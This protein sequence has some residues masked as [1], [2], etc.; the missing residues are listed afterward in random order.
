MRDVGG[1]E[2][3]SGWLLADKSVRVAWCQAAVSVEEARKV[4]SVAAVERDL[5][6][7]EAKD[8]QGRCYAVEAELKALRDQQAA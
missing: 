1:L 3:I 2:L 6:L 5:A 8:A 4:A 7:K